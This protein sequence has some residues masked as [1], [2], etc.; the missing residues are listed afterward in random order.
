R[1]EQLAGR[2]DAARAAHARALELEARE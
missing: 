1:A 2:L